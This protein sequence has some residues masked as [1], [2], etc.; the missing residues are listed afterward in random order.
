MFYRALIICESFNVAVVEGY[1]LLNL[2]CMKKK[3]NFINYNNKTNLIIA[4]SL[5][6]ASKVT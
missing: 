6:P 4:N 2:M 5:Q 1:I 3:L